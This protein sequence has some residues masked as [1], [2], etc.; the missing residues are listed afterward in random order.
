MYTDSGISRCYK[1]V[2]DSASSWTNCNNTCAQ[3]TP[4]GSMLC[5]G[6]DTLNKWI[7][8]YGVD[9]N[10]WIGYSAGD[11]TACDN[12]ES[13]KWAD[14]CSST[15]DK[16]YSYWADGQPDKL[17]INSCYVYLWHSKGGKWDNHLNTNARVYCACEISPLTEELTSAVVPIT[18]DLSPEV[19]ITPDVAVTGDGSGDTAVTG[20]GSG[21]KAVTGDGSGHI[22]ATGDR[23]GHIAATGDGSGD[24]AVTGDGS[25]DIASTGDG[26]GDIAATGDGSGDTA[27]TGDGSGDTAVT[28]DE[29]GD[30]AATGVGSRD[31]AV[32]GD[33]SGNIAAT[34]DGSGDK[35]FDPLAPIDLD[36]STDTLFNSPICAT[37]QCKTPSV[38]VH[39][40]HLFSCTVTC[41]LY[42]AVVYIG[43]L[44][45]INYVVY[46]NSISK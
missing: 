25:G 39:L 27:A 34:G 32:T 33:G 44:A 36:L 13:Y 43:V 3:I 15:L 24:I 22:A 5:P 23:S 29:S 45:G 37:L 42:F 40:N 11:V 46:L 8:A 20:D 2:L 7:D 10:I 28:G 19:P 35:A 31:I 16:N 4:G 6:T 14:T 38:D 30:I 17:P 1:F 9:K 41:Q 21:D 18:P 12:K 26:S